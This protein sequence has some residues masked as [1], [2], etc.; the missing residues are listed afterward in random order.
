MRIVFGFRKATQNLG[1]AAT[2]SAATGAANAVSM[3]NGWNN[4]S[5]E[6]KHRCGKY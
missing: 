2:I 4:E 5:V 1:L 3:R 6:E